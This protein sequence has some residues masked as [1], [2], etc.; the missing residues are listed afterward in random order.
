MKTLSVAC[1]S[2][3]SG[4]ALL[5]TV[6]ITGVLALLVGT[7]LALTVQNNNSVKRSTGWNTALPLAEAG[8][9]E[10]LTHVVVNTNGYGLDGWALSSTNTT[11]WKKRFLSDSYYFV[12][13]SGGQ[14]GTVAITSTGY[15]CWKG[16]NYIARTVQ[17]LADTPF[18]FIPIG[19]EATNIT[20]GGDFRA[21]SYDSLDPLHSTNGNYD[22]AKATANV[23]IATPGSSFRISGSSTIRGYLATG[24]STAVRLA[25]GALIG[26]MSFAGPGIQAGHLTNNFAASYPTIVAPFTASDPGVQ[27]PTN[28][29]VGGTTYTYVL[30]G[31]RYFASNLDVQTYGKTLYVGSDS[32]LYVTGNVDLDTVVFDTSTKPNLKVYVG[33]PA[34]TFSPKVIGGTPPQ[35][36]VF[37][38]PSCTT[39]SLTRNS[40]FIGVIYAPQ[41]HLQGNG[42]AALYGAIVAATFNCLGTFDFHYDLSTRPID[43]KPFK[44][45]S[46]AEL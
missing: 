19:L 28:G 26:D 13:I 21:D 41:V 29:N 6:F 16:S 22:H 31:G 12:S 3:R 23:T 11:Y 35:F 15:G 9:E 39:L 4:S 1:Q 36:W 33:G 32:T 44:I 30:N 38:L 20:F 14:G 8:V 2:R 7:Y 24:P 43:P 40:A 45:I 37:G 5:V 46:W 34:V 17:V 10:A 42:N 18:P 25:G 27:F